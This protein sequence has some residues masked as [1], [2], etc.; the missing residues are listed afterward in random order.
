MVSL[1][2]LRDVRNFRTKTEKS[3]KY[4][5]TPEYDLGNR[6]ALFRLTL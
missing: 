2:N 5:F 4:A 6:K 1:I 3:G